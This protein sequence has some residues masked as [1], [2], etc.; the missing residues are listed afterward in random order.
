MARTEPALDL[1]VSPL[2]LVCLDKGLTPKKRRKENKYKTPLWGLLSAGQG[3]WSDIRLHLAR[4][5]KLLL[6]YRFSPHAL[7]GKFPSPEEG[8]SEPPEQ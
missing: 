3:P 2:D 8:G 1:V 5:T 6:P 7:T 4:G